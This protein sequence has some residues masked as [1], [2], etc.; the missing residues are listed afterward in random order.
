M[1]DVGAV[2]AGVEAGRDDRVVSYVA[3]HHHKVLRLAAVESLFL[4]RNPRP[5]IETIIVLRSG[6]AADSSVNRRLKVT[7]YA[8]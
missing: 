2:L 1:I 4:I 5:Y 8:A 3:N 6:N 7:T